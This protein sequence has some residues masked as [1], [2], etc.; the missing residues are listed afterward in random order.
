MHAQAQDAICGGIA[1]LI[2]APVTP[3]VVLLFDTITMYVIMPPAVYVI[4]PS[5]F[6]TLK[7]TAKIGVSVSVAVLF[8]G[9]GS[10]KPA[11]PGITILAVLTKFPVA[12]AFTVPFMVIVIRSP[13]PAFTDIPVKETL[14]PPLPF[15]PQLAVPL[16]A[17]LTD[18]IL[19]TAGTASVTRKP[20]ALFGPLFVTTIW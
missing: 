2:T 5:L 11:P 12:P 1:S 13:A 19:I 3:V 7:S 15:V 4:T 10:V 18:V 17:Q 6:V 8:A 14:F 9:K 16:D 20:D